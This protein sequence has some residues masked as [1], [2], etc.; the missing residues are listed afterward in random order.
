MQEGNIHFAGEQ[1]SMNFQ[2]FMEGGVTT[3][4]RVANTEIR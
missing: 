1:T 2:G 3:G 4:E